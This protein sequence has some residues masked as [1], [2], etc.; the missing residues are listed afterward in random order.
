[1]KMYLLIK[2]YEDGDSYQTFSDLKEAKKVFKEEKKDSRYHYLVLCE[3]G[4]DQRFG[5]SDYGFD[6]PGVIAEWSRDY[7]DQ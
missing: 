6:G 2:C 3:I 5:F 1:M 7:G 4:P